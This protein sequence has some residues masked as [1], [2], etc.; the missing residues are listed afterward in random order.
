MSQQKESKKTQSV[1]QN[2]IDPNKKTVFHFNLL[3]T[4]CTTGICGCVSMCV[5]H[6][7]LSFIGIDFVPEEWT[8]VMKSY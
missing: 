5:L 8:V 7:D 6:I 4:H 1:F 3:S 2:S